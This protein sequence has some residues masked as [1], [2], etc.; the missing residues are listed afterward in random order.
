MSLTI[1]SMFAFPTYAAE[2]YNDETSYS[3]ELQPGTEQWSSYKNKSDILARLQIPE[4]KL[5]N[6]T[7]EALLETVLDYPYLLDYKFFNTSE[8]AYDTFYN[9][10]N[11]FRELVSRDD[12]T[13]VLLEKYES[14]DV[15]NV[16]QNS[17]RSGSTAIEMTVEPEQFFYTSTIE[18]LITCDQIANGD[19]T[20]TE[21]AILLELVNDKTTDRMETGLYSEASNVYEIFASSKVEK[22]SMTRAGENYSISY[23]YTPN[24][25]SVQTFY[26]RTPELTTSEKSS[27]DNYV[28]N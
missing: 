6:M 7:T 16:A 4:E 25:S 13:N 27:C 1:I 5:N 20:T 23:V 3:Y 8:N 22:N 9:D 11:G 17:N 21:N 19:Y 2:A 26:N 18:F 14:A 15:V 28:Q 12:L 10:F 24:G